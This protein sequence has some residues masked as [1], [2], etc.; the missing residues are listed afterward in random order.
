MMD[1]HLLMI[2]LLIGLL[3]VPGN[4]PC[5]GGTYPTV[6]TACRRDW[7]CPRGQYCFLENPFTG[8]SFCCPCKYYNDYFSHVCFILW[9]CDVR[10]TNGRNTIVIDYIEIYRTF[11]SLFSLNKNGRL[12]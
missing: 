1:K 10:P 11:V 3:P 9:V 6:Y 12:N 4:G 7:H 5:P 8:Y 2:L